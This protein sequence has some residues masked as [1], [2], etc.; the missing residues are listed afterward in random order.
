MSIWR[1]D[2]EEDMYKMAPITNKAELEAENLLKVKLPNEY[3]NILKEQNGGYIIYDTYPNKES[4]SWDDNSINI[5]H[6][7]ME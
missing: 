4:T 5:D 7:I 6:V 2:N 1:A 3:L